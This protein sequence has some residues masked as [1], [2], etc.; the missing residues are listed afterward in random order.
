MSRKLCD[1]EDLLV[2]GAAELSRKR[3]ERNAPL[4]TFD[5]SRADREL[6]GKWTR[7]AGF[8]SV[9]PMFSAALGK[10]GG[11]H[12]DPPHADALRIE[13]ALERLSFVSPRFQLD[14]RELSAGLGFELDAAGALRAA[15]GN[16]AN[17]VLV[18]GRLA[19]GP[20]LWL[21]PL[22]L[23][24]KLAPNGRPGTWRREAW[25]E[26]TFGDHTQAVR[27]LDVAVKALRKDVYPAGAF[28]VVEFDP[29]PTDILNERA[30]YAAWRTSLAWLAEQLAGALDTR[31]PLPPRAAARPWLGE[32]DGEPTCD[33]F[34]PGAEG[35]FS[36]DEVATL[37]AERGAG[38]R[39]PLA[40]GR[41]YG[42]PPAKPTKGAHRA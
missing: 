32:V 2:W 7:P 9:H 13:A 3:P 19:S 38:R 1:V 36:G 18:H 12:G 11:A 27:E 34:R 28:C 10:A 5:V 37:V 16:A 29:D 25:V 23:R 35:V 14:E 4:P 24:P 39:R 31:M 26:P 42:R 21:E 40:G 41:V 17:L 30:E 15:L 6:V 8:P 20:T 33:I 22:E